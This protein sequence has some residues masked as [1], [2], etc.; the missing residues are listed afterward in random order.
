M[1]VGATHYLYSPLS[2]GHAD[3]QYTAQAWFYALRGV[4]GAA[5]FL[6]V[7]LL[8]R[9]PLVTAVCVWGFFEESQTT[10]CR[11]AAGVDEKPMVP[12]FSGLCGTDFYWLGVVAMILIAAKIAKGATNERN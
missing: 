3:P 12:L 4:E 7:G 8:A 10:V 9:H 1:L 6:V 11:L 2:I 5:L